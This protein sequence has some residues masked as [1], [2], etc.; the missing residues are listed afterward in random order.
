MAI[1]ATLSMQVLTQ[2]VKSPASIDNTVLSSAVE[3]NVQLNLLV[4]YR[5]YHHR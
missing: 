3:K 1:I 2:S 4:F 5:S